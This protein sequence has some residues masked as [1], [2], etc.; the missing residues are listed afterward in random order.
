MQT[1]GIGSGILT[2]SRLVY[3][4]MRIAGHGN[5]GAARDKGKAAIRAAL[6]NGYTVFDHADIYGAGACEKL[7]GEVLRETPGMREEIVIVGK[8]GIRRTGTDVKHYDLSKAY[9]IASVEASL[10]RLSTDRLDLLLL[11]RPDMLM[12][13]G[14]IADAF[15]ELHAAGRVTAFGVS[16]FSPSQ[17]GA[18]QA[19]TGHRLQVNQVE[20]NLHRVAAFF[21]GTLDQCQSQAITP[22]AWCPLAVV[23]YEAW[24]NTLS[25]EQTARIMTELERQAGSYGVEAWVVVLAWLLRHPAG[26]AP[27]VGST[28]PERIAAATRAL[29]IDYAREDWYRL[30]EARNGQPVP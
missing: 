3:G 30:L 25:A 12:D 23:A 1:T 15:D 13:Y 10:R 6:D 9:I 20:I 16:N 19:A 21:D 4:C 5:G 2:G 22:Q 14:E 11:H 24:G 28:R 17:V 26:I 27:I 29:D 18:L 8:C 7:F